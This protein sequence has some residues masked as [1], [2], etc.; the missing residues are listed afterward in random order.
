MFRNF[1]NNMSVSVKSNG[2]MF[3]CLAA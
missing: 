1:I 3:S 2:I